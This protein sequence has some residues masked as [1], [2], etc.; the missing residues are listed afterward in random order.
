M[1]TARPKKNGNDPSTSSVA[2]IKPQIA[3]TIGFLSTALVDV[4]IATAAPTSR[5][6][7]RGNDTTPMVNT[8]TANR[9]PMALPQMISFRPASV[10]ST[11]SA[12]FV[13]DS[14]TAR[15]NSNW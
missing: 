8:H 15:P 3:I 9:K 1:T 12:N 5:S 7:N 11:V 14:G 2:T 13:I 10:V 6:S 4:V